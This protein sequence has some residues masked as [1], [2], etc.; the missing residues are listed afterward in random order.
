MST[1]SINLRGA[2]QLSIGLYVGN[3][4]LHESVQDGEAKAAAVEHVGGDEELLSSDVRPVEELELVVEEHL[5]EVAEVE[6][7]A[8][9]VARCTRRPA[10]R[11]QKKG[12]DDG[13]LTCSV[14]S[15]LRVQVPLTAI[16][17]YSYNN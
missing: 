11:F 1:K 8:L 13:P 7:D 4:N 2:I 5:D 10:T 14:S 16:F 12:C 9:R 3:L 6:G 17:S 15:A